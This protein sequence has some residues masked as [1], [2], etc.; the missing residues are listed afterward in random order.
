MNAVQG[1]VQHVEPLALKGD[2]LVAA[3]VD[4]D[5][6]EALLQVRQVGC[7]L[8]DLARCLGSKGHDEDREPLVARRCGLA[9]GGP[10]QLDVTKVVRPGDVCV[11][12]FMRPEALLPVVR[13]SDEKSVGGCLDDTGVS[14]LIGGDRK[15]RLQKFVYDL[16]VTAYS[17]LSLRTRPCHL[18]AT[19]DLD[20][21]GLAVTFG[22][23]HTKGR[24]VT[25][26]DGVNGSYLKICESRLHVYLHLF[27]KSCRPFEG[28]L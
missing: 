20:D 14:M 24:L 17:F 10:L 11:G 27:F 21:V 16:R 1:R 23:G 22:N 12:L 6:V 18:A 25:G 13:L 3:K 4:S 28:G 5:I 15:G 8:Q 26:G 7:T 2:W 19:T 9:L